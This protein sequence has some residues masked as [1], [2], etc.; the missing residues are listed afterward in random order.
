MRGKKELY[1]ERDKLPKILES[2]ICLIVDSFTSYT[3]INSSII[4]QIN[5]SGKSD[6]CSIFGIVKFLTLL[7]TIVSLAACFEPEEGCLDIEAT[8]FQ[9]SADRGCSKDAQSSCFCTYPAISLQITQVFDKS[10][11]NTNQVYQTSAGENIRIADIQFYMSDIQLVL[12]DGQVAAT[13][14]TI[15]LTIT[16][17]DQEKNKISLD[18]FHLITPNS[19]RISSLITSDESGEFTQLQ[20]SIGIKSPEST[21]TPA[22]MKRTNHVLAIDSMYQAPEGYVFNRISLQPDTTSTE[23]MLIQLREVDG[24][25]R[26][27]LDLTPLNKQ[28]GKDISIETLQINHAKWFDGINF[29]ENTQ[30]EVRRKIVTNTTNVFSILP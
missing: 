28:P 5:S 10:T 8:N 24:L 18:D 6:I 25:S 1:S 14:D 16:E 9:L 19:Q 27:I 26:I 7:L 17:G 23:K 22:S 29:A 11:F 4:K 21:T 20:F 30:D 12:A 2:L 13:L 15:T 3:W